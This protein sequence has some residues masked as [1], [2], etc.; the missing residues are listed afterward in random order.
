MIPANLAEAL[1]LAP[2]PYPIYSN[3]GQWDDFQP[4]SIA[5]LLL[6]S[7]GTMDD[8]WD[9]NIQKRSV[10]GF[11]SCD[12]WNLDKFF[13]Y[14]V[15][16]TAVLVNDEKVLPA[17][18]ENKVKT[19]CK[20]FMERVEQIDR[21]NSSGIVLHSTGVAKDDILKEF[22]VSILPALPRNDDINY[23]PA[24]V[25]R[26]NGLSEQ[27]YNVLGSHLI[28][29]MSESM[30]FFFDEFAKEYHNDLKSS[31]NMLHETAQGNTPTNKQVDTIVELIPSLWV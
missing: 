24:V 29:V 10:R 27:D 18:N 9:S 1:E 21:T 3:M 15:A 20:E 22:F 16:Y 23:K 11:A 14:L 26:N 30:S 13:S 25:N 17:T 8:R 5:H 28:Y 4:Y 31:I 12:L 6:H 19:W 7:N 2:L